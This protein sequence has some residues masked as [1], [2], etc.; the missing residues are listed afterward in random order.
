MDETTG[1]ELMEPPRGGHVHTTFHWLF[2]GSGGLLGTVVGFALF[3]P[4]N[5]PCGTAV[6][7]APC[8]NILGMSGVALTGEL[9]Y[10]AVFVAG[11]LGVAAGETFRRSA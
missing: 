4:V 10:V 7:P 11:L 5:Q 3:F 8:S 2:H 9:G 6:F 1:G